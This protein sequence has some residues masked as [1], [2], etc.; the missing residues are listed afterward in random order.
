MA[1]LIRHCYY[2]ISPCYFRVIADAAR[3]MLDMLL[4]A[5]ADATTLCR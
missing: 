1:A 4:L 2:V 3:L 5:A